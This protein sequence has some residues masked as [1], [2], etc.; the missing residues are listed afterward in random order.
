MKIEI[1]LKEMASKTEDLKTLI[2][3]YSKAFDEVN[4]SI[5]NIK[6]VDT[7][8]L[9]KKN[10]KFLTRNSKK[11]EEELYACTDPNVDELQN[12]YNQISQQYESEKSM[13]NSILIKKEKEIKDILRQKEYEM[14]MSELTE[15][16]RLEL[17][18]K[19]ELDYLQ[20]QLKVINK[21]SKELN[22]VV[23]QVDD[24]ITED[25]KKV[26]KIDKDIQK[27]KTSME[28]GN[29]ELNKAEEYQKAN[30]SEDCNIC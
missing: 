8:K 13:W 20:R 19:D 4:S 14:K 22:V 18:Q 6:D 16:E 2:D 15:E 11:I 25:H 30:E 7:L 1:F 5:S 23:H 28:K 10:I 17:Q 29:K 26:V 9:L 27:S 3:Q 12:Q 24:V 21:M